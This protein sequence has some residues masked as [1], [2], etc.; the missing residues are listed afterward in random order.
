MFSLIIGLDQLDS[1]IS[2]WISSNVKLP[3]FS[4]SNIPVGRS[5]KSIG[6]KR[7]QSSDR[8]TRMRTSSA[9]NAVGRDREG[10]ADDRPG[11]FS[12]EEC[13]SGLPSGLSRRRSLSEPE[14]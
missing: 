4:P 8:A 7:A 11:A 9:S 12:A 1:K 14:S 5:S 10:D 2:E 6:S 3:S 13:D